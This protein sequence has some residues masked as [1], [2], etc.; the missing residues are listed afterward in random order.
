MSGADLEPSGETAGEAW[1]QVDDGTSP[2]ENRKSGLVWAGPAHAQ[3]Q[4][5]RGAARAAGVTDG[6]QCFFPARLSKYFPFGSLLV[7]NFAFVRPAPCPPCSPSSHLSLFPFFVFLPVAYFLLRYP[8]LLVTFSCRHPSPAIPRCRLVRLPV[9]GAR[10]YGGARVLRTATADFVLM[11][12]A[13]VVGHA[14]ISAVA[15]TSLGFFTE[16]VRQPLFPGVE[17]LWFLAAQ[18]VLL[19]FACLLT[20]VVVDATPGLTTIPFPFPLALPA[21]PPRNH[22][23]AHACPG[24]RACLPSRLPALPR[25]TDLRSSGGSALFAASAAAAAGGKSGEQAGGETPRRT[26][27]RTPY[28]LQLAREAGAPVA[29]MTP[30]ALLPAEAAQTGR[31]EEVMEVTEE[32]RRNERAG[33]EQ[34][35]RSV[36]AGEPGGS[37]ERGA[38]DTVAPS[39]HKSAEGAAEV[40]K[41]GMAEPEGCAEKQEAERNEQDVQGG[42]EGGEMERAGRTEAEARK[43]AG[44]GGEETELE[45][46]EAERAEAETA[47]AEAASAE[48]AEA[49]AAAAEAAETEAAEAEAA[50]AEAAEAEA[51]AA[52]AAETEAA[53]AEAAAAEAAEAEAAEA[54]AAEAEG[55]EPTRENAKKYAE[56]AEMQKEVEAGTGGSS[57][58][59]VDA[60]TA[61]GASPACAAQ[62]SSASPVRVSAAPAAASVAAAPARAAKA[63]VAAGSRAGNSNGGGGAA[64]AGGG[65]AWAKASGRRELW[66]SATTKAGAGGAAEPGKRNSKAGGERGARG[67]STGGRT[68]GG[69]RE[70][71]AAD[72]GEDEGGDPRAAVGK[73]GCIAEIKA[74]QHGLEAEEGCAREE[75][76]DEGCSPAE[77]ER[78]P[79]AIAE[80]LGGKEPEEGAVRGDEVTEEG[81]GGEG[82]TEEAV[83]GEEAEEGVR[84][85]MT[86]RLVVARFHSLVS[87]VKAAAAALLHA[88]AAD[89]RATPPSVGSPPESGAGEGGGGEQGRAEAEYE[90]A[91]QQVGRMVGAMA[92]MGLQDHVAA[93]L[94]CDAHLPAL[95][96]AT[97]PIPPSPS[98][99]HSPALPSPHPSPTCSP[100]FASPSSA[101]PYPPPLAA[102]IPPVLLPALR[103]LPSLPPASPTRLLFLR[104][105]LPLLACVPPTPD[106]RAALGEV[107]EAMGEGERA[108]VERMVAQVMRAW[109]EG[110]EQ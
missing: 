95:L 71:R 98:P 76:A 41:G 22:L 31:G 101:S 53:E 86:R 92:G 102:F 60:S 40:G 18:Y 14:A 49:E 15:F 35:Q 78:E 82:A 47:E 65:G 75:A 48:A 100:Y 45:A 90:G 39:G 61:T 94:A 105:W 25:S 55:V 32:V 38:E 24:H 7:L 70:R 11:C 50:E 3:R 37:Q 5:G 27:S 69:R 107:V 81:E 104:L 97:R 12:D 59:A 87:H 33:V 36:G 29:P 99:S 16:S 43:D 20:L 73:E 2:R 108:E 88:H 54:E 4:R 74:E 83:R 21:S 9:W 57:S 19:L 26:P 103:L 91:V 80:G 10:R 68:S 42:S 56:A 84:E 93:W 1:I 67:G 89:G 34:E 109:G 52:E 8:V 63:P 96:S 23:C 46:T 13:H 62:P 64:K 79:E 28:L 58:T 106:V 72:E 30:D 17:P 44:T 110:S 66:G 6:T 51:A 85:E 77:G